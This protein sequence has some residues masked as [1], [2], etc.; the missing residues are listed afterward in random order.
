MKVAKRKKRSISTKLEK[1]VINR[2][3]LRNLFITLFSML[4]V[5]TGIAWL[6]QVLRLM[7]FMVT[8]RISIFSFLH[9]TTLLL[10]NILMVIL[11]ITLF[12]VVLFVYNRLASDREL[13]AMQATGMNIKFLSK[14][15]F[16]F[17]AIIT[18]FTYFIT[19]YLSPSFSLKFRDYKFNITNSVVAMLIKEGEFTEITKG[20]TLYV[21]EAKKE[22]LFE[23]FIHDSRRPDRPRTVLA[24]QGKISDSENGMK[25][26][27]ANGTLQEKRDNN[28]AFGNFETYSVDMGILKESSRSSYKPNELF[29][30]QLFNARKLGY[31]KTDSSF[32][33]YRMDGHKRIITPLYNIIFGLLAL[34]G[35]LRAKFNR[36]K[37]FAL[38]WVIFFM[39]LIQTFY[40]L[41]LQ[42]LVKAYNLWPLVYIITFVIICIEFYIL[43]SDKFA[44]WKVKRNGRKVKIKEV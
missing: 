3:I 23:V 20:V 22:G 34:I 21:K 35:L 40:I 18:L 11:P 42:F 12:A 31:A 25:I 15:A 9:F 13:I 7:S 27:L 28:Y 6:T 8:S 39:G 43:L 44:I 14:P 5:L 30:H 1:N 2:Y 36:N 32:D 33:L 17:I 38:I 37:N 24:Q 19:F 29:V 16:I 41:F 10:P 26:V 4:F